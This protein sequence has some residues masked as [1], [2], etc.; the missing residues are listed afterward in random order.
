[1]VNLLAFLDA[2]VHVGICVMWKV[3]AVWNKIGT[4]CKNFLIGSYS[5]R[6]FCAEIVQSIIVG[7]KFCDTDHF[8]YV[9][10]IYM[11]YFYSLDNMSNSDISGHM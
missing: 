3:L 1:M 9:Q 10:Y 6:C 8:W 11:Y 5:G 7:L 4:L 2:V